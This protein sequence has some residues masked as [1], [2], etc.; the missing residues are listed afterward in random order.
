[1]QVF[2]KVAELGSF[3]G[4]ADALSLS[5]SAVSKTVRALEDHLGARLLN[6]TTRRLSLTEA[7]ERYVRHVGRLLVE[8][9]EVEAEAGALQAVARGRLRVNAPMSFGILYLAPILPELLRAEPELGIDLDL[10]DRL[11]DLVDEGYDVAIRIGHLADSSLVARKLGET[12]LVL[13][14]AKSYLGDAPTIERVEDLQHHN[15]L[16]YAYGTHRADWRLEIDGAVVSVPVS[17]RLRANNGDALIR[18]AEQGLGLALLPDF[19]AADALARG[20][21]VRVLPQASG[22]R[23]PIHALYPPNRVPLAKLNVFVAHVRRHLEK[24]RREG[25]T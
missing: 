25:P 20:T 17:G 3:S 2:Q 4:A 24:R 11:V 10:N 13:V 1:M 23:L 14:A 9:E 19:I 5:K 21:L 18:A 16:V 12:E 15:C 22:D 7:G 8:L 6:R